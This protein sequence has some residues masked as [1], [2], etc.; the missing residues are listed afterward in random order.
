MKYHTKNNCW[1]FK[2]VA[3]PKFTIFTCKI[4]SAAQEEEEDPFDEAFDLLAKESINKFALHDIEKDLNDED[5]FDTTQADVVLNLASIAN[6]NQ[7]VKVFNIDNA[8][9]KVLVL[10]PISNLQLY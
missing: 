7:K 4:I 8:F 10:T 1:I 3:T 6:V 2:I 5:L 9:V